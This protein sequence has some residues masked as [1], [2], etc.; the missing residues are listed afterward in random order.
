MRYSEIKI[1]ET[2]I[3]EVPDDGS[4]AGQEPN[5]PVK[6]SNIEAG[7]PYPKE[8]M[9]T[10]RQMQTKLEELGYNVG[11]TGVDG[12]Y[13]TRT[14]RAVRAFKK[15]F[16]ITSPANTMSDQELATLNSAEPKEQPTSTG[17]EGHHYTSRTSGSDTLDDTNFATGE[18]T[19][20][21]RM[22]NQGAT[23]DQAL[24]PS[25]MTILNKAAEA[26]GVDVVVFSGGQDQKG[27]PGAKRTGSVRHDKGRAADIWIYSKGKRLRTDRED[28]IVANFIAQA[29]AAGAKGIGAGPGYMGG[30]GIHVDILGDR[31]GANYWGDDG[32]TAN[33]PDY[34]IAA[35]RA[36]ASGTGIA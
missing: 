20:R 9:D 2:K 36:G 15:D 31:A 33:T 10:V 30:V 16:D 29:V 8:D 32:R 26:A 35:Y 22:S 7:P 14:T 13:G 21:V 18:G 19:G 24:Q 1:V 34:V 28:P 27:T 11:H 25:L 23:R 4:R 17:N 3:D 5:L 6:S 12:K